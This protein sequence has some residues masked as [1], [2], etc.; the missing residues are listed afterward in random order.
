MLA[1]EKDKKFDYRANIDNLDPAKL[2]QALRGW[3]FEKR[4]FSKQSKGKKSIEEQ[5]GWVFHPTYKYGSLIKVEREAKKVSVRNGMD[6]LEMSNVSIVSTLI[7]PET[8]LLSFKS[9]NTELF[10][11]TP[12]NERKLEVRLD[13]GRYPNLT[14]THLIMTPESRL[15]LKPETTLEE[16]L[17]YF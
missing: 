12:V 14:T 15:T 5:G 9:R 16:L 11:W 13:T 2:I 17:S 3:E 6:S 1:S 10:I 8:A 4:I 7:Y